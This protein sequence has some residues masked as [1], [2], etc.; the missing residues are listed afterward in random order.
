MTVPN[1]VHQV[2]VPV[3]L[4]EIVDALPIA[5]GGAA[6]DL[7]IGLGGHAQALLS[8]AGAD[9][10]YLGIDRDSDALSITKQRLGNDDRLSILQSTYEEIWDT[11]DYRQWT[12]KCAPDG[13]DAIL[14]DLGASNLQLKTA[15]RGFSFMLE[16]PLDMRMDAGR[17][18]TALD[19]LKA[20]DEKSLAST[21]Y[22]YGEE[23]ASR[24]IASAILSALDDGSLSTTLD[25]ANAVYKVLPKEIAHRKKQ[26]DPA[27]RTFQAIRI[28]VNSELKGLAR[29]IERAVMALKAKGRIAVISFHSL[30]DRIVKQTFRRLSGIYSGPGRLPTSELPKI[31]QLISPHGIRP[32]EAERVANPPS[33][34]ARLRL[35]Q[36]VLC[37]N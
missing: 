31:L 8:Q 6:I 1:P 3:M 35:A 28:A 16:G 30:E 17:G 36:R 19:W 9:V 18:P 26:I 32:S 21:L 27:T 25:L 24:P 23:R 13:A 37:P 10:R 5:N 4:N 14:A 2:H 7:T 29:A 33:R 12:A 34:S 11:E 15:D 20:Q 22:E